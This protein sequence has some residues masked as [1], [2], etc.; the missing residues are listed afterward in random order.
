MSKGSDL[1]ENP[2]IGRIVP[3]F[4]DPTIRELIEGNYRIIYSV[5]N[6][7]QVDILR[8]FHSA[9]LLRKTNIK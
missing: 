4:S 8:I 5:K 1:I 2:F 7:I 6:E 9:R 3:E